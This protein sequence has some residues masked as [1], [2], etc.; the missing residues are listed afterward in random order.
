MNVPERCKN[1]LDFP[2]VQERIMNVPERSK[3]EDVNVPD[4][5]FKLNYIIISF[6]I[7]LKFRLNF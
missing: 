2:N 6:F 1:V 3:K 4:S 5:T 7:Q